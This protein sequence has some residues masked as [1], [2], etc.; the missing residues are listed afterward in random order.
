[1][2]KMYVVNA[3]KHELLLVNFCFVEAYV[4]TFEEKNGMHVLRTQ[5]WNTSNKN[6]FCSLLTTRKNIESY[7]LKFA[8]YTNVLKELFFIRQNV[9]AEKIY[10]VLSFDPES[11][12][13]FFY[14]EKEEIFTFKI[15]SWGFEKIISYFSRIINKIFNEKSKIQK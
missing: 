3:S 8:C 12:F 10:I 2:R 7:S 14:S 11:I 5:M 9:E 4:C 6:T 13:K 1:M 15:V